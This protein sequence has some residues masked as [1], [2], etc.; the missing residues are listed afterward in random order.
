MSAPSST[1][2]IK[3]VASQ[4]RVVKIAEQRVTPFPSSNFI[5]A[6]APLPTQLNVARSLREQVLEAEAAEAQ[7]MIAYGYKKEGWKEPTIVPSAKKP[8]TPRTSAELQKFVG[9]AEKLNISHV[10]PAHAKREMETATLKRRRPGS[11]H[12]EDALRA[13]SSSSLYSESLI[14]RPDATNSSNY[15]VNNNVLALP[16]ISAAEEQKAIAMPNKVDTTGAFLT[17]RAPPLTRGGFQPQRPA[18]CTPLNA[19]VEHLGGREKARQEADI[20]IAKFEAELRAFGAPLPTP[21]KE[22]WARAQ[23]LEERVQIWREK[24]ARQSLSAKVSSLDARVNMFWRYRIDRATRRLVKGFRDRDVAEMRHAIENGAPPTY[25][26][27]TSG[28]TVLTV[29]AL[30]RAHAHIVPVMKLG[31]PW[32]KTNSNGLFPLTIAVMNNDMRCVKALLDGGADVNQLQN[33]FPVELN[34][35]ECEDRSTLLST[36]GK[37]TRDDVKAFHANREKRRQEWVQKNGEPEN[38]TPLMLAA[39]RGLNG[40]IQHLA[41]RKTLF[42]KQNKRGRTALIFAARFRQLESVRL[43]LHEHCDPDALDTSGF[44]AA[45]WL[46]AAARDRVLNQVRRGENIS[47]GEDLSQILSAEEQKTKSST[48]SAPSTIF[49][50]LEAKVGDVKL[51]SVE[52]EIM[53]VLKQ[54]SDDFEKDAQKKEESKGGVS[55]ATLLLANAN[56]GEDEF[57]R[58]K[59][60]LLA[61]EKKKEEAAAKAAA[62]E[63][64][65]K[66]TRA[67]KSKI[68]TRAARYGDSDENDNK[69]ETLPTIVEEQVQPSPTLLETGWSAFQDISD[70]AE[71]VPIMYEAQET[72]VDRAPSDFVPHNQSA[73]ITPEIASFNFDIFIKGR[74]DLSLLPKV[75]EALQPK[76]QTILENDGKKRDFAE[77]VL[78]DATGDTFTWKG[79]ETPAM[80]AMRRRRIAIRQT[81]APLP[82]PFSADHAKL[83]AWAR[84]AGGS[85]EGQTKDKNPLQTM[86]DV[87]I[88]P[89]STVLDKNDVQLPP[90]P[91]PKKAKMMGPLLLTDASTRG[92]LLLSDGTVYNNGQLIVSRKQKRHHSEDEARSNA[93]NALDVMNKTHSAYNEEHAK[94]LRQFPLHV[95]SAEFESASMLKSA[96]LLY[97]NRRTEASRSTIDMIEAK[98]FRD[99]LDGIPDMPDDVDLVDY[100]QN[101]EKCGYCQ[102]QKATTRCLNCGQKQCEK[103]CLH[104]HKQEGSR[105]HRVKPILPRGMQESIL[106]SKQLS[107]E[108]FIQRKRG[109]EKLSSNYLD[110]VRRLMRRVKQRTAMSKAREADKRAAAKARELADAVLAAEAASSEL[111]KLNNEGLRD[112]E[113]RGTTSM[114]S[115]SVALIPSGPSQASVIVPLAHRDLSSTS[116]PITRAN[117]TGEFKVWV[118]GVAQKV[119]ETQIRNPNSFPFDPSKAERAGPPPHI[120]AKLAK[121]FPS[122]LKWMGVKPE[123]SMPPEVLPPEEKAIQRRVAATTIATK[124]EIP[125]RPSTP[126]KV[127]AA[128]VKMLSPVKPDKAEADILT[129]LRTSDEMVEKKIPDETLKRIA[130]VIQR[131]KRRLH[132]RL[133]LKN[134]GVIKKSLTII[135]ILRLVKCVRNW[136]RRIRAKVALRNPIVVKRSLS[137]YTLIKFVHAMKNWRR[138]VRKRMARSTKFMLWNLQGGANQKK[139]YQV[140][141]KPEASEVAVIVSDPRW[142][143]MFRRFV[144][145]VQHHESNFEHVVS[146]SLVD[147]LLSVDAYKDMCQSGASVDL[148]KKSMGFLG[149]T[150]LSDP[151]FKQCLGLQAYSRL[152][153]LLVERGGRSNVFE[154]AVSLICSYLA[155]KVM[156][157]FLETTPGS[158]WKVERTLSIGLPSWSLPQVAKLCSI[159]RRAQVHWAQSSVRGWLVRR[160]LRRTR[161]MVMRA[162]ARIRGM[163][164]RFRIKRAGGLHLAAEQNSLA[165]SGT[166][167]FSIAYKRRLDAAIS[168]NLAAAKAELEAQ[169]AAIKAGLTRE[170]TS[171]VADVVEKAMDEPSVVT[172]VLQRGQDADSANV[173]E[174]LPVA[175]TTS[176]PDLKVS[177]DVQ[178]DLAQKSINVEYDGALPFDPNALYAED[179]QR[180]DNLAYYDQQ[181]QQQLPGTANDGQ[182]GNGYIYDEASGMYYHPETG[183]YFDASAG[184]YYGPSGELI[185]ANAASDGQVDPGFESAAAPSGVSEEQSYDPAAFYETM[186]A[187]GG[188]AVI[189]PWTSESDSANAT[190]S[191]EQHDQTQ[192]QQDTYEYDETLGEGKLELGTDMTAEQAV[193]Y[194][195]Y[196]ARKEERLTWDKSQL[197]QWAGS[198]LTRIGK[199]H[200][201]RRRIAA[202]YNPEWLK[203]LDPN[204]SG[205]YYYVSLKT[206]E[207]RW[208]PPKYLSA[209]QISFK[210]LCGICQAVLADRHCFGCDEAYCKDCF[211][212][213][214]SDWDQDARARRDEH[215]YAPISVDSALVCIQCET[216]V[217]LFA[218]TQC[219]SYYC[220][221]CWPSV[222]ESDGRE[223]HEGTSAIEATYRA[224][225]SKIINIMALGGAADDGSSSG[226]KT[227]VD[228]LDIKR[229]EK[230]NKDLELEDEESSPKVEE[231]DDP[232]WSSNEA[233]SGRIYYFNRKTRETSWKRPAEYK[234]PPQTP[235]EVDVNQVDHAPL[236]DDEDEYEDLEEDGVDISGP[237]WTKAVHNGKFYYINRRNHST[238]YDQPFDYVEEEDSEDEDDEDENEEETK[239]MERRK[240]PL[241]KPVAGVGSWF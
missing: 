102:K 209:S 96:L 56:D 58:V 124:S 229:I 146:V 230:K 67:P 32:D 138:R 149:R 109:S 198:M 219:A 216:R 116:N 130:K 13:S 69:I 7:R 232:L 34:N 52:T 140:N 100:P 45:D 62:E 49:D 82:P 113:L 189:Q 164:T 188:N 159:D 64:R 16:F 214:H 226:S 238:T 83:P 85:Y 217:G 22:A 120:V 103:C 186:M 239:E 98:K 200:V 162:Q 147:F 236:H 199:G 169:E 228:D 241:N 37:M 99:A 222:H 95:L 137:M 157:R 61:E 72:A 133:A 36:L 139:K 118:P 50:A 54:A 183:W 59:K 203:R 86:I 125:A 18:F 90:A 78:H 204:G 161:F 27:D 119:Q 71:L 167:A 106:L 70:T 180:D 10:V 31:A 220:A 173:A 212:T 12:L 190:G 171:S 2:D 38:A 6:T 23:A 233:P 33:Y 168:A 8:S 237:V 97:K 126:I 170:T 152:T 132:A 94:A 176:S 101:V 184:K 121:M 165:I 65:R 47:G 134:P 44:S 235:R 143:R 108:Q 24:I 187:S 231:K 26:F 194:A 177:E 40:L 14:L 178:T 107:R 19:L 234:T 53:R 208:V 156:P 48:M 91:P 41:T 174:P 151:L 172:D 210:V 144:E 87:A 136:S 66:N 158:L 227:Y 224:D 223:W 25:L 89:I 81:E 93:L 191:L 43:L 128:I 193:A 148:C 115:S 35:N 80:E 3:S 92:P 111:L 55:T 51:G 42:M 160:R 11:R 88:D 153:K 68:K 225:G 166:A 142:A 181:Q 135:S 110:S 127:T 104:I 9:A 185:D 5:Y 73:Y 60:A 207:S 20:K 39:A 131:W 154:E 195:R 30:L 29:F 114:Q 57:E 150:F 79:L 221:R 112:E 105:H 196:L 155:N 163:I 28:E 192:Q 21:G 215:S 1:I 182:Y 122:A 46:R 74:P 141:I 63:L 123:D 179:G 201:T 84:L 129:N 77:Q 213:Y 15:N 4:T 17:Y 197:E 206:G 205:F 117:K 218:C 175:T 202:R 145:E 75:R 76:S 240:M 211:A